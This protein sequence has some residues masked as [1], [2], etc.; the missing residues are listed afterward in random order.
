MN[1][2]DRLLALCP[3]RWGQQ[4]YH[5]KGWDKLVEKLLDDITAKLAKENLPIES[6]EI[7]QTKEKFGGLRFYVGWREPI[8]VSKETLSEINSLIGQAEGDSFK[9]CQQCGLEGKEQSKSSG[10]IVT[11]CDDCFNKV[12]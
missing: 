5:P 2:N 6:M 7:H 3:P 8:E 1:I 10:W 12:K 11:I 9:I 4:V